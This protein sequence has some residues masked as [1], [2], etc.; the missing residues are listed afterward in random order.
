M[1][2]FNSYLKLPERTKIAPNHPESKTSTAYSSNI[3]QLP[4]VF[5]PHTPGNKIPCHCMQVAMSGLVLSTGWSAGRR[6]PELE[7]YHV[8]ESKTNVEVS[9]M[10]ALPNHPNLYRLF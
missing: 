8:S 5:Y 2:M 9:K 4:S 6:G 1:A 3:A 10:R 7:E